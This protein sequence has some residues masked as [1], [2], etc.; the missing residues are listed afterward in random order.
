MCTYIY[1]HIYTYVYVCVCV[2]VCVCVYAEQEFDRITLKSS[3]L[4]D[5]EELDAV[6]CPYALMRMRICMYVYMYAFM[7]IFVHM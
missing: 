2:C 4:N 3:L 5:E 6:V 1:A 7:Y